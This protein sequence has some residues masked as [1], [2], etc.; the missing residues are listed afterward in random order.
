MIEESAP[1]KNKVKEDKNEN[2]RKVLLALLF[3][4]LGFACILCSSETALRFFVER[5]FIP[6][7]MRSRQQADYSHGPRIA[8]APLDAQIAADALKDEIDLLASPQVELA[9]GIIVAVAPFSVA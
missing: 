1:Q 8:L 7:T 4:A 3:L 6:D 9:G 2:W 5:G